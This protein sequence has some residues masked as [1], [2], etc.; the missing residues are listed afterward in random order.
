MARP[1]DCPDNARVNRAKAVFSTKIDASNATQ[2]ES[3]V[4]CGLCA[5]ACQFYIQTED[6]EL[7]PIHKLDLLEALLPPREGAAA[8]AASPDRTRHHRGGPR[9]HPASGVRILYRV[10]TLRPG[11]SDG[12]R[13]R[14]DGARHPPG[15]GTPA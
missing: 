10:R 1:T 3:C 11:L 5:E 15:P 2:L 14:L 4:H 12:D 6:P 8:L 13:Y 7:T 9:G